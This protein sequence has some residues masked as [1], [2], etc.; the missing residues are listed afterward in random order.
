MALA[1]S[2]RERAKKIK[3]CKNGDLQ[4]YPK[5]IVLN[6]RRIRT[7][8]AFLQYVT[9]DLKTNEAVRSIRTPNQGH[10]VRN[11]DDL[12]ENKQYVACGTGRFKSVP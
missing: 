10:S 7:W 12:E 5:D 8:D 2:E 4:Y 3:I 9:I 11:L 6:K 1:E